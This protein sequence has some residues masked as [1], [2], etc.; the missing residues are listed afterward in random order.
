MIK[1]C[2]KPLYVDRWMK[3]L[4]EAT[5]SN[6]GYIIDEA[7]TF[8]FVGLILCQGP[9]NKIDNNYLCS[10]MT[11]YTNFSQFWWM[12]TKFGHLRGLKI[13][14]IRGAWK[15]KISKRL[16]EKWLEV[17][18]VWNFEIQ[19]TNSRKILGIWYLSLVNQPTT[20]EQKDIVYCFWCC[21]KY[22]M[23]EILVFFLK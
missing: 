19:T 5:M 7:M 13:M 9:W 22:K 17:R 11:F 23:K 3:E 2:D 1:S 10:W 12:F 6:T 14:D 16:I 18:G 21:L 20:R 15:L 4:C 8:D